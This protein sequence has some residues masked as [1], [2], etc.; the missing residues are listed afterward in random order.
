[1]V[2]KKHKPLISSTNYINNEDLSRNMTVYVN[3]PKNTY[4]KETFVSTFNRFINLIQMQNFK[5]YEVTDQNQFVDS[6][7]PDTSKLID[8]TD[9][10][11]I[12][13]SNDN[14]TATVDLMNGQTNSNKQYIIQQVVYPDN[15]STDNGKIDYTLDTD[16]TKYSWSNSYSR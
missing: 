5:I 9:K 8:V 3:Q 16:K 2:I 7:T 15:T 10:F 14:K 11:K 4:T 12:T 1:M 13:Y 6:F